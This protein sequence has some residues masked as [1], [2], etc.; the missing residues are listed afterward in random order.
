MNNLTM[1]GEGTITGEAGVGVTVGVEVGVK[2]GVMT[3]DEVQAKVDM[4]CANTPDS[5]ALSKTGG[6]VV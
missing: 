6:G 5:A 1:S 3:G 4:T 2:V